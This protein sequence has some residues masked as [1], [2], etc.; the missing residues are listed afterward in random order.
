[1]S[2]DPAPGTLARW[3]RQIVVALDGGSVAERALGPANGLA[4]RIGAELR[5][6]SVVATTPESKER[7]A[8]LR[9]V[10]TTT[11]LAAGASVSV[12]TAPSLAE[13]ISEI[14]DER[15][16]C[17]AS[18][19]SVHQGD[20]YVGSV[21]DDVVRKSRR[22]VLVVGPDVAT[23]CD[24]DVERIDVAVG[25]DYWL[26]ALP[27]A[28]GWAELLG[29]PVRLVHIAEPGGVRPRWLVWPPE[30]PGVGHHVVVES[31]DVAAA[32]TAEAGNNALMV[33]ATAGRR[34]LE[35]LAEGSIAAGVVAHAARP[36]LL[37]CHDGGDATGCERVP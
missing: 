28:L 24:M 23:G 34:G 31:R 11:E 27:V 33:I 1:M 6:V 21:T 9:A 4:H 30:C 19:A 26:G 22:P 36:V 20:A 8:Y 32:L 35:R 3:P 29:V 25:G 16:L 17:M 2:H 37:V 5:L 13:A 18:H 7:L 12:I 15:V 14:A 10:A